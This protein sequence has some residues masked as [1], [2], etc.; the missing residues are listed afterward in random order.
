MDTENR[1]ERL[2]GAVIA[3][4]AVIRSLGIDERSPKKHLNKL[5]PSNGDIRKWSYDVLDDLTESKGNDEIKDFGKT[6]STSIQ[7]LDLDDDNEEEESQ[8]QQKKKR[9]VG[10][11]ID[12]SEL[13]RNHRKLKRELKL[14]EI[15]DYLK[16]FSV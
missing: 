3:L 16:R 9:K 6:V 10:S 7:L 5:A 2:E 4:S 12:Q 15:Y 1:I 11:K 13:R 8:P 14:D